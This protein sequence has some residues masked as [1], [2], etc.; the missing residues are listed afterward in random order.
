[1][2]DGSLIYL[3]LIYFSFNVFMN[4]FKSM[5][6]MKTLWCKSKRILKQQPNQIKKIKLFLKY[7]WKTS[8]KKKEQYIKKLIYN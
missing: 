1:M 7:Q 6:C 2:Y 3:I 4:G 5:V 8:I